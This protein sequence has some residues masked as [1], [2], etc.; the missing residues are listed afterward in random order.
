MLFFNV[1]LPFAIVSNCNSRVNGR[2]QLLTDVPD[3]HTLNGT[4][5]CLA[6]CTTSFNQCQYQL[7]L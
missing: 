5:E 1:V 7:R 3:V 6:A 2:G 4:G